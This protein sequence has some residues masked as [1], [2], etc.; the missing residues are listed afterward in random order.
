MWL[1]SKSMHQKKEAL[2][3]AA[4]SFFLFTICYLLLPTLYLLFST[5]SENGTLPNKSWEASLFSYFAD[6]T[7][8]FNFTS[9]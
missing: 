6:A 1:G 5:Y 7:L 8:P 9:L 2:D 4:A 3:S